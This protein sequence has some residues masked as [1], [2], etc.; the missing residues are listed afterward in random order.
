MKKKKLQLTSQKYKDHLRDYNKNF[1]GG[2][3]VKN[4]PCSEGD[5]SS[6]PGRET[7]I[8]YAMGQLSPHTTT[9]EPASHNKRSCMKQ[10]RS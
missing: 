7:N 4:P 3:V 6:T 8:L 10:Q 5:T 9:R 2:P 1:L